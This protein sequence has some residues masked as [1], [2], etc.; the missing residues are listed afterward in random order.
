[1]INHRSRFGLLSI[2]LPILINSSMVRAQQSP[3]EAFVKASL[4]VGTVDRL[5]TQCK[6]GKGF[7]NKQSAAISTWET[8]QNVGTIRTQMRSLSADERQQ[9]D[10]AAT[11]VIAALSKKLDTDDPCKIATAIVTSS[12]A[13]VATST[14]KPE[15]RV[16]RKSK[17]TTTTAS[18]STIASRVSEIDSFGFD[19]RVA[20]GVGGFL[21]Q[22]IYPVVLFQNGTAL[23]KVEALSSTDGLA[24][25]RNS[26]PKD[27]T[28]W[29]RNNGKVQLLSDKGWQNLPFPV[30]Y[31]TLPANFRLNGTYR[32]LS[33]TGNVAIGGSDSVA[34][35][36]TYSF[37]SAGRVIRGSGAGS[38]NEGVTSSSVAADRR[39][40]YQ[41]DGLMLRM[42]YDDGSTEQRLIIA[43]PKDPKTAIWLDGT[44]YSRRK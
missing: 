13:K 33:G 32:S 27:W 17:S 16:T 20:M 7:N 11:S 41:I 28:K 40:R 34:A 5:S 31:K 6:A 39:G 1:M 30:T 44:G 29:R 23:K 38:S 15:Q 36:E 10:R 2:T 18:S 35:W 3:D 9:I 26:R 42:T 43:N 21:T 8:E 12:T 22:D 24:E 25:Q 4:L 19:T 14:P 37:T